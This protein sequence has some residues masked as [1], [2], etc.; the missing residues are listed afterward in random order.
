MAWI[1]ASEKRVRTS[2]LSHCITGA[3][4]SLPLVSSSTTRLSRSSTALPGN[5]TQT[6]PW[7]T[8]TGQPNSFREAE[9]AAHATALEGEAG[10]SRRARK[11]AR[12]RQDQV[13]Q[14]GTVSSFGN[15]G[16]GTRRVLFESWDF[17]YGRPRGL[18]VAG[19]FMFGQLRRARGQA[20][21]GSV[22]SC[23]SFAR[24]RRR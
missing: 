6:L 16:Q 1:A 4:F 18:R 2:A 11:R 9:K 10:D 8:C 17:S 14:H 21:R 23:A 7:L 24:L 19:L 13:L 15:R 20:R 5:P 3:Y 22:V 12:F